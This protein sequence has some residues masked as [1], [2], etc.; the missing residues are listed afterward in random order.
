MARS[1]STT[2]IRPAIRNILQAAI[3]RTAEK[4]SWMQLPKAWPPHAAW[5]RGSA[6]RA[7][8]KNERAVREASHRG[9]VRRGGCPANFLGVMSLAQCLAARRP[10]ARIERRPRYFSCPE[11]NH[12]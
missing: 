5:M 10:F 3:A 6:L 12:G 8:R 2:G 4:K 9:T 11:V 7:P 1:K